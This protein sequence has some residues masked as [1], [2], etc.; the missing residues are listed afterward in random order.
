MKNYTQNWNQQFIKN[1]NQ[2]IDR[3]F[4]LCLE[5]GSFEGLTSN[6]IV[7]N[8]LSDTGKLICID[9]LTDVY[10]NDN[11]TKEDIEKNKKDFSYFEDQY[12]RFSNNVKEHLDTDRIEL[13]R[14]LST[15]AFP[16]LIDS[17]SNKFDF[18]YIDGDHRPEGVYIDSIN[19]F[20][21]C[22]PNGFILLDDYS[23]ENTG[24]GI[25]RFLNEYYG[26]YE[27]L[28]KEYQVL[29]KKLDL[30]FEKL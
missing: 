29:I 28:I 25:D 2:F 15:D 1:T 8:L 13:M 27:L 7:D 5:I 26:R 23:W 11:L 16:H 21:L 9:P 17:H 14:N 24:I 3:K 10:L 4:E 19:S 12:S 20:E 30:D 6:Y 18:I 22:K